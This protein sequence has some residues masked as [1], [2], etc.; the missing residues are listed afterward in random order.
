MQKEKVFW[1]TL[2][3]NFSCPDFSQEM[4]S[5]QDNVSDR[6]KLGQRT[7]NILPKPK[8]KRRKAKKKLVSTEN[9]IQVEGQSLM[10]IEDVVFNDDDLEMASESHS[11]V[12]LFVFCFVVLKA[13]E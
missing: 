7:D 9:V 10:V 4:I 11:K 8:G 3:S 12:K 1:I 5:P 13:L 2:I 6:E